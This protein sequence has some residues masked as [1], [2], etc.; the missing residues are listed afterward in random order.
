MANDTKM[1]SESRQRRSDEF[2]TLYEDIADEL[3]NYR[4][5]F[6]GKHVICPCDWDE[7]LDEVCVYA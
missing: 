5:Q 6:A 7:S 3:S 4:A 1:L 2:Y